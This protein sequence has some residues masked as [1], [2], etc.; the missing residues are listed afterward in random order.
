M[1]ELIDKLMSFGLSKL[2]A[3]VYLHLLQ[4]GRANGYKIAKELSLSRSSVYGSIDT[5]YDNG[6][7]FLVKGVSKE[8]EAKSPELVLSRIKKQTLDNI[9]LLKKELSK[10]P[11]C[12]EEHFTYNLSGYENLIHKTK[13]VIE[14]SSQELYINTDFNLALFANELTDAIER[15]VRV[16]CFSFNRMEPLVEGL[17][18]YYRNEQPEVDFPSKRFMVVADSS[19]AIIFSN[20]AQ[21]QG[22]Y[23]NENLL[24]MIVSEHIHTDIY[25]SKLL[26]DKDISP[27]LLASSHEQRSL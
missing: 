2:D 1:D 17:E 13:E 16:I 22:I 19:K 12:V 14:S 23:T 8:Y 27:L 6:Y 9:E 7:I 24:V 5:L 15:G 11:T 3:Q 10:L 18:I 4:Q 20:F 25:L 21:A 26:K